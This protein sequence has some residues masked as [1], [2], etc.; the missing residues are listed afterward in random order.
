M[1][2]CMW[3]SGTLRVHRDD[4]PTRGMI[5]EEPFGYRLFCWIR[6]HYRRLRGSND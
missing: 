4:C 3:C 1:T 5:F 6:E 2:D